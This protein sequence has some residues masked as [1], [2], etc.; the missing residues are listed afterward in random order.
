VNQFSS[1]G[2]AVLAF[3]CN[4]FNKSQPWENDEV[5][6]SLKFMRPGLKYEANYPIFTTCDVNGS[7]TN[8][9]FEYLKSKQPFP[10][11]DFVT[12]SSN[13]PDIRLSTPS[14]SISKFINPAISWNPVQR[15]D[16]SGNFEKFLIDRSG[17]VVSRYT[18][19][20]PIG[21]IITEIEQL[22]SKRSR[23]A[24]PNMSQELANQ[25]NIMQFNI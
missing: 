12:L 5:I 21:L 8:Q 13:G 1:K 16:I 22:L 7:F 18:R 9:I 11:D 6:K 19:R 20:K 23:D 15:S 24:R 17:Q 14:N 10:F 2:F 3:P 25:T 4:Q